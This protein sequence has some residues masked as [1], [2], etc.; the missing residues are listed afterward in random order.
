[1]LFITELCFLQINL[2]LWSMSDARASGWAFA[3][4]QWHSYVH[5]LCLLLSPSHYHQ[6]C[7][8]VRKV[9]LL[10]FF[11]TPNL[12]WSDAVGLI[13][14]SSR[15]TLHSWVHWCSRDRVRSSE[16]EEDPIEVES[17]WSRCRRAV[18]FCRW[19]FL[20]L[21]MIWEFILDCFLIAV[22]LI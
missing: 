8:L 2:S 19:V 3:L 6:K 13:P 21:N 10:P 1:M 15:L 22:E 5:A 12:W 16:S 17:T 7:S 14:C 4:L 20:G 11:C 18:F 9:L